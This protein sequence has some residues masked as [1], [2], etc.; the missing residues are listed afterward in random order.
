MMLQTYI[1]ENKLFLKVFG[2]II[3]V[4]IITGVISSLRPLLFTAV[5]LVG[6]L[7]L[8][9]ILKFESILMIT[10]FLY[11]LI[12]QYV[13]LDLWGMIVINLQRLLLAGLFLAWL[14]R[15][16]IRRE[17]MFHKTPLN[18]II[19]V[20]LILRL[21]S[22]IFSMDFRI[23][24]FN[25]ISEVLTYFLFY[26]LVI[27][28]FRINKQIKKVMN[29]LI[30]SGIFVSVLGI[31]EFL[32][33]T[34]I[35]SYLNPV[36]ENIGLTAAQ[37]QSRIGFFRIEAGLGH[38]I[39]LGMYLVALIPFL[40]FQLL[41]ASTVKRFLLLLSFGIIS[42][43]ILFSFSRSAWIAY[44][45]VL[46]CYVLKYHFKFFPVIVLLILLLSLQIYYNY[47][48]LASIMEIT[49]QTVSSEAK[50]EI[51]TSITG[52]VSQLKTGIPIALQKPLT[53]YGIRLSRE[54]GGF[55]TLDNYYLVIM[56]ESGILSLIALMFLYALIFLKL[57][58]VI[59]IAKDNTTKNLAF[60][61]L[62]SILCFIIILFATALQT[63]FFI[64]WLI[65]ALGMR[66]V[67]NEKEEKLIN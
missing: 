60:S 19:V 27:D 5:V 61:L 49:K 65:V 59:K 33:K 21:I 58:Y 53:G 38:S 62:V 12:P 23:S 24:L 34:N 26:F 14:F 2:I 32:F 8:I 30:I 25:F 57:Q 41:A 50:S 51:R 31:F 10:I 36:R 22:V 67:I 15:K 54:A 9:M 39:V 13:G 42:L 7:L 52:R 3:I 63:V 37:I 56:L 16:V 55:P 28:T 45:F 35:Y 40:L 6:F 46:I 18:L 11:P 47:V 64:W 43:G 1:Y 44:L 4:S 48:P 20:F 17:K 29:I 66:L